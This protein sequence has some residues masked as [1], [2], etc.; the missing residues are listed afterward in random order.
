[1]GIVYPKTDIILEKSGP[2]DGD[3]NP[4][5]KKWDQAVMG[6]WYSEILSG[7]K[8]AV[9]ISGTYDTG[10]GPYGGGGDAKHSF[11]SRKK[12]KFGGRMSTTT[13]QILKEIYS[14]KKLSPKIK[15]LNITISGKIVNWEIVI[16]ESDDGKAYV[17]LTSRGGA[18]MSDWRERAQNQITSR[19]KELKE[20]YKNTELSELLDYVNKSEAIRQIFVQYTIPDEYPYLP[21]S[22]ENPNN[23]QQNT[24]DYDEAIIGIIDPKTDNDKKV[25][26]SVT[27]KQLGPKL[28]ALGKVSGFPDGGTIEHEGDFSSTMDKDG[29][30]KEMIISLQSKIESKYAI[31][32]KL[33]VK[34]KKPA[35]TEEKPVDNTEDVQQKLPPERAT[36]PKRVSGTFQL[37]QKSGP[38]VIIGVT[39]VNIIEG[40][41]DFSGIQFD[42]PGDYVIGVTSKSPDIDSAATEI[43]IKVLPMPDAIPQDPKG[44]TASENTGS[45][46][47]IAQID[48]A[49]AEAL[50]IKPMAF[51]R[52]NAN[53]TD[54]ISVTTGVGTGT[55]FV[56]YNGSQI[57]DRDIISMNLYHDGMIPK[58]DISFRD[59]NGMIALEP[60]RDNTCFEIYIDPKSIYLKKI[61]LKMQIV[62]HSKLPNNA[63]Q[64]EGSLYV[65][66]LY[67]MKFKVYRG[68]SFNVLK[69]ICKEL[70]LGFNS[71]IDDTKD[72]MPW[73][74][75]G[76]KQ[77]KF[78]EEI[79]KH[80]YISEDSFMAG[81]I[82]YYYCFNYVDVEKEMQRDISDDMCIDTGG[83][84][85]ENK[86]PEKVVSL[87]LTTEKGGALSNLY[88]I[89]TGERNEA[90]K[91]SMEQGYKTRT[92]FYDKVKK[93][94][95]VFDVDS[96]TSDEQKTHILK[97]A[98]GDTEAFDNNYVTKY[99]GKIDTDN[100]H[101]NYNYAVTQNRINLDSMVK[102]Q[103]D[104]TLPNPNLCLYK[105]M[106]VKAFV[107][108]ENATPAA[109]EK[110]QWR[111]SGEWLISDIKFVFSNKLEQQI[112]L[113]R[114]EIGKNP[115]EIKENGNAAKK[116]ERTEKNNNP[117]AGSQSANIAKPNDIYKPGEEYTVQNQNGIKY[118]V[119]IIS[120][121]ENG[122]EVKAEIRDVDYIYPA[123]TN[124]G[125]N[126]SGVTQSST[127]GTSGTSGAA[128]AS[129]PTS[130]K[131]DE[132]GSYDYSVN[133]ENISKKYRE[134][135][136]EL[137]QREV[138]N[139]LQSRISWAGISLFGQY[140]SI[141][142]SIDL[143]HK[144]WQDD[145]G[146]FYIAINRP[147]PDF[148]PE[149]KDKIL[150]PLSWKL[151][152]LHDKGIGSAD[153]RK[154]L[155][156]KEAGTSDEIRNSVTKYEIAM[157]RTFRGTEPGI[158]D[159]KSAIGSVRVYNSSGTLVWGSTD[160]S[161]NIKDSILDKT[162]DGNMVLGRPPVQKAIWNGTSGGTELV[163]DEYPKW[164]KSISQNS[165]E[166]EVPDDMQ[167]TYVGGPHV[168]YIDMSNP[169]KFPAGTYTL[170]VRYPVP[171]YKKMYSSD[172]GTSKSH[173]RLFEK[174][175]GISPHEMKIFKESFTISNKSKRI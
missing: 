13:S 133:L 134:S 69:T 156:T 168:V 49:N 45:R 166:D 108:K 112:T 14:E 154:S 147:I 32:V 97:G 47:I 62:N 56:S 140:K 11:E 59:T 79:V 117:I 102:I 28:A 146:G 27:F 141:L 48:P 1:M 104:I 42:Q 68:T 3:Y 99:E 172:G 109:P 130:T 35:K 153:S 145:G 150:T 57:N 167:Y 165:D 44:N 124:N 39:E 84:D 46:P 152:K 114:K 29:L 92:K 50:K 88:F 171:V 38:G 70:G 41:A 82:D 174:N 67:R 116:E 24:G 76:D 86:E 164:F 96:T 25:I 111:W 26:G 120:L 87:A 149:G 40:V 17:S 21:K 136:A 6:S 100:T 173:D 60:P 30:V 5:N 34:E 64:F 143:D 119:K 105:Y 148:K 122:N 43:K 33:E 157:S 73:R 118:V 2:P 151:Y 160:E 72:E 10:K 115:D 90:T 22:S 80:S 98:A 113:V 101:K 52:Q 71:N 8:F 95:L 89:K 158:A 170:E 128:T 74:N 55:V 53:S 9:K 65:P 12:D 31:S 58:V 132:K 106:K 123:N 138:T 110:I 121:S 161:G 127:S 137:S 129:V 83:F 78:M 23:E 125:Q 162:G 61:H 131:P 77:F 36:H 20:T 19:K 144:D 51:D 37:V 94:F 126:I 15:S 81:Y 107:V 135:S 18:G 103:M 155:Y 66:E 91:T 159:W 139:M 142:E 75:I 7:P 16:E 63:Y 169:S 93:M 163:Y 4:S 175:A 85:T 54:S